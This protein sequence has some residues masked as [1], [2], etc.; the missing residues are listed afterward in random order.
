MKRAIAAAALFTALHSTSLTAG[1]Q[2]VAKNAALAT[3]SP[4]ATQ[5][6]LEVM[7]RGGNAI[8]AAVAVSFA[9][10][11][12]HPQAG[13]IG[14]GGFLVYYEAK[15]RQVWTLDYREVA[16]RDAK[17]DMY[18]QRDGTASNDSQTGPRAAAIPGSVAGLAEMHS[19]FG[20]RP[21]KELLD[22]AI[23][24]AK[25]GFTVDARLSDDLRETKEKRKIDQFAATASLF[26]PNGAALAPTSTF[27]QSDLAT[28]L[29]RIATAGARDFYEGDTAKRWIEA[30]RAAGAII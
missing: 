28:T 5:V 29:A 4:Y 22:P 21:W 17:K 7:K 19:R 1:S 16:P 27:A 8:D 2:I 6:G 20:T 18:V 9:L 25:N 13:N 14:G 26:F 24:I 10:A 12:A 15:T 30:A 3:I 11:V 23:A